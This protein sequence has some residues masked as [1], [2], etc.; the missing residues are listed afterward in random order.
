MI[1]RL[2]AAIGSRWVSFITGFLL[3]FSFSPLMNAV[4]QPK[5]LL[6]IEKIS[7]YFTWVNY[8]S[9]QII[10]S[11]MK[12]TLR[13]FPLEFV[14]NYK[15]ID[16]LH[17]KAIFQPSQ[18]ISLC[19]RSTISRISWLLVTRPDFTGFYPNILTK[20]S[21]ILSQGNV[22]GTTLLANSNNAKHFVVYIGKKI[23]SSIHQM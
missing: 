12:Q 23:N 8:H 19:L 5:D 7:H 22:W 17:F 20:I 11:N 2:H 16:C 10:S 21:F 13:S 6:I 18:L 9:K 1:I 14:R 4:L 3:H 15:V